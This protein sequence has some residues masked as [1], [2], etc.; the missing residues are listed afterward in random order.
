ML[1]LVELHALILFTFIYFIQTGSY[2]IAQTGLKLD[3]RDPSGS[4]GRTTG[5]VSTCFTSGYFSVALCSSQPLCL[6]LCQDQH[7]QRGRGVREGG[8]GG[9]GEGGGRGREKES[10]SPNIPKSLLVAG[11]CLFIYA[12]TYLCIDPVSLFSPGWPRTLSISDSQ[13]S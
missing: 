8:A 1:G 9:G 13:P 10:D 7:V 6:F 3:S 5:M 12:F 2:H 4:A 11:F